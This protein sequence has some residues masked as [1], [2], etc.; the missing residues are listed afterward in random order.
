P[1]GDLLVVSAITCERYTAQHEVG[2]R[3]DMREIQELAS[4]L[5]QGIGFVGIYH[6][7][8]GEV[9][10]SSTDDETAISMARLY[11]RLLSA[12]TNDSIT[13]W[14]RHEGG[15]KLAQFDPSRGI[16][17]GGRIQ[18]VRAETTVDFTVH[19][20]PGRPIIPQVSSALL[21]GFRAAW[22]GATV[23][24]CRV[25][26]TGEAVDAAIAPVDIFASSVSRVLKPVKRIAVKDLATKNLKFTDERAV[27][28]RIQLAIQQPASG[29]GPGTEAIAGKLALDGIIGN[30][31]STLDAA[32]FS[33]QLEAE[34]MDDLMVKTA[35][36]VLTE[37]GDGSAIVFPRTYY[38]PYLAIPLKLRV[39]AAAG[40][41]GDAA[42]AARERDMVAA[43]IKRA[44]SMLSSG[45]V[46]LG[47]I[48]VAALR[49]IA[50]VL[51]ERELVQRC[52]TLLAMA[53]ELEKEQRT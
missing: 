42:V 31:A 26:G 33:R 34:I 29:R 53:A 17:A 14:Y 36:A 24:F 32:V 49:E 23:E 43:M 20:D 3:P 39:Q 44:A 9:F 7:H 2:A 48:M 47:R 40:G 50:A 22:P 45:R 21:D 6:S 18:L 19:V 8:P 25:E 38:M 13:K 27:V 30:V 16:D 46:T 1:A 28:A 5:P 37:A 12:V 11:P 52:A 4:S 10:H 51:N 35:R 41:S 15:T